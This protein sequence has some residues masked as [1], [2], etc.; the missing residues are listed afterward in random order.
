MTIKRL[1]I[2]P[3]ALL[4]WLTIAAAA[5]VPGSIKTGFIPAGAITLPETVSVIGQRGPFWI[6]YSEDRNYVRALYKAGAPL[7]LPARK[8]TCLTLQNV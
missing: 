1:L 8:K 3:T 5:M 4:A 7:V 6:V 2:L